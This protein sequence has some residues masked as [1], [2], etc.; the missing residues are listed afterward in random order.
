MPAS[1][2]GRARALAR[3]AMGRLLT[4][5]ATA[6]VT[7]SVRM[8]RQETARAAG[9]AA[10]AASGVG[11]G[12]QTATF[13]RT[14]QKWGGNRR[15]TFVVSPGDVNRGASSPAAG[16][17][18]GPARLGLPDSPRS[19]TLS[20]RA[21]RFAPP[22]N[23]CTSTN[24]SSPVLAPCSPTRRPTRN[25]DFVTRPTY[26]RRRAA[27]SSFPP[28]RHWPC[29]RP[30]SA[31]PKAWTTGC[32]SRECVILQFDRPIPGAGVLCRGVRRRE[33]PDGA[34]ADGLNSGVTP[35]C[36]STAGSPPTGTPWSPW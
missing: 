3:T 8:C 26:R 16:V 24:T 15:P 36:P 20:P 9:T 23:P 21:S 31:L 33:Q 19:R 28:T 5:T 29:A 11:D 13:S 32:P 22:P 4:P 14:R 17:G 30:S 35:A 18:Q 2:L 6:S 10:A 7:T 27:P 12:K 1:R 34:G 25:H